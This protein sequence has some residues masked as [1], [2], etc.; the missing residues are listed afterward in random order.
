MAGSRETTAPEANCG[1]TEVAPVL[2]H[3]QVGGELGGPKQAVGGGVDAAGFVDALVVFFARV[4]PAG[5]PL[6][7]RKLVG[8]IAVDFVAAHEDEG[9]FR[10]VAAGCLQQAQGGPSVDVEVLE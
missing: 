5:G 1:H 6:L 3:E 2:L 8:S 9:R 7:Q 4:V 10:A